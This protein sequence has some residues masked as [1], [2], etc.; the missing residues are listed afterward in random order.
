ME[1]STAMVMGHA[2]LDVDRLV[3]HVLGRCHLVQRG[4]LANGDFT[5]GSC[6]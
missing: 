1:W 2:C 3:I 5:L 4:R 6:E